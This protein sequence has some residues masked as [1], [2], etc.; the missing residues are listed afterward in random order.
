[1][2]DLLVL[3]DENA[4][5]L[6]LNDEDEEEFDD[7]DEEELTDNYADDVLPLPEMTFDRP[8]RK[9]RSARNRRTPCGSLPQDRLDDDILETPS[10]EW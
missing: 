2:P 8:Q 3:R 4:R 6:G 10:M 7:E 1:V 5:R 9:R